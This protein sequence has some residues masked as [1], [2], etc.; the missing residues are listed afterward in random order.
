MINLERPPMNLNNNYLVTI[1]NRIFH[2]VMKKIHSGNLLEK[3]L[4]SESIKKITASAYYIFSFGKAGY[5]LAKNLYNYLFQCQLLENLINGFVVI[6]YN[7]Y[8]EKEIGNFFI[9]ESSHPYPDEQSLKNGDTLL[10]IIQELPIDCNI[11]LLLS[12]GASSLIEVLIPDISLDN[13]RKITKELL[14]SG[15]TIIEI[16]KIRSKMSLIKGGGLAH[17]LYPRK[18]YQYLLVDVIGESPERFVGS[19]LMYPDNTS[20]EE[21]IQ[22]LDKYNIKTSID[23]KNIQFPEKKN[24]SLVYTTI[25]GN[26]EIAC[27]ALKNAIEESGY[28]SH[29]LKPNINQDIKIV[30]NLIF[31]DIKKFIENPNI[32]KIG[33]VWGGEPTVNVKG[34]GLGGRSLELTIRL[35]LKLDEYLKNYPE[36]VDV[37]F[38]SFGTD[39]IDGPTDVAGGFVVFEKKTRLFSLIE[40]IYNNLNNDKKKLE[41]MLENNDSYRLIQIMDSFV[42]SPYKNTTNVNDLMFCL[43]DKTSD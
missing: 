30:E 35:G 21:I 26:N 19:G 10:K 14:N 12:G 24:S 4:D 28:P 11:I 16:N 15:A 2:S 32:K 22:I 34:N 23:W 9:F 29:I 33:L 27:K 1:G 43:I 17:S 25:I 37:F 13:Y 36:K 5:S 18:V 3:Q 20:I 40:R 39:G 38:T 41:M 31:Q 7:S 6:P 8:K 42:H